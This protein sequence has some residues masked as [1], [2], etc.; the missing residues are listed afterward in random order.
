MER[1]PA[2][3]TFADLPVID[4]ALRARL[5]D[6]AGRKFNPAKVM[7]KVCAGI[8]TDPRV[9]GAALTWLLHELAGRPEDLDR[10]RREALSEYHDAV[11]HRA[12][13]TMAYTREFVAEA[14]RMYS[15]TAA[16]MLVL[17]VAAARLALG[18]SLEL[19][20][21]DRHGKVLRMRLRPTVSAWAF[22]RS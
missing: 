6:L 17:T 2:L 3:L 16:D 22:Q 18:Y 15:T 11:R 5:H 14:A 13:D 9:L 12:A 21:R 4:H 20:R 8:T 19:V 1:I 10:I 7:P